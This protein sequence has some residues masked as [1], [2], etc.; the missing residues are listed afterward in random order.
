[1]IR[2]VFTGQDDPVHGVRTSKG[3]VREQTLCGKIIVEALEGG[4]KRNTDWITTTKEVTC[5][6]CRRVIDTK[7]RDER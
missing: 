4:V 6:T 5:R 7:G 1:M 2:V 3:W